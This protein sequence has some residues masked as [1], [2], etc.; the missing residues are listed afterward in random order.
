MAVE[1]EKTTYKILDQDIAK[2]M[3]YLQA[4]NPGNMGIISRTL[5]DK[6][7]LVAYVGDNSPVKY[8][9]YDRKIRNYNFFIF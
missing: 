1:Y 6:T 4:L 9:K 8:Y 3:E 2:D 7:W 5:D